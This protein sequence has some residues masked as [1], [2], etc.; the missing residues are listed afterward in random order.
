MATTFRTQD[1][2]VVE[3]GTA[4][5]GDDNVGSDTDADLTAYNTGEGI[6]LGTDLGAVTDVDLSIRSTN[7]YEV[8]GGTVSYSDGT[9]VFDIVD[10]T[11]SDLTG[12]ND[13][14]SGTLEF[15]YTAVR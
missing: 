7:G 14:T 2:R 6:T 1:E 9:I 5:V 3:V 8:K 4:A 11:G 15:S 13:I 10:N 12:D